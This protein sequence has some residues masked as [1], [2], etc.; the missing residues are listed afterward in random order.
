[1]VIKVQFYNIAPEGAILQ[2]HQSSSRG[3]VVAQ[4]IANLLVLGSSPSTSFFF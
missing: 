3:A 2:Q 1:M 4:Q